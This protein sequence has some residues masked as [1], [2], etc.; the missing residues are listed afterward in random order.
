MFLIIE[1]ELGLVSKMMH[2]AAGDLERKNTLESALS[3]VEEEKKKNSIMSQISCCFPKVERFCMSKDLCYDFRETRVQPNLTF[4]SLDCS[5]KPLSK[6]IQGRTWQR[7]SQSA[8]EP[9]VKV[10]RPSG[11]RSKK[12][13]SAS[14][15]FFFTRVSVWVCRR[16]LTSWI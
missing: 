16:S 4:T 7:F 1:D 13:S 12:A 8:S 10:V 3:I 2:E 5:N 9:S 6:L 15:F 11:Q 14:F